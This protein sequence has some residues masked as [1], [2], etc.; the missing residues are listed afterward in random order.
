[1]TLAT[2]SFLDTLKAAAEEANVAEAEY[3]REAAQRIAAL[4]RQRAF[5]FRRLNLMRVVAD[6]VATAESEEI[7]VAN[8]LA[9]LRGKLGWST[10]TE[11][12]TEVLSR[13]APVA[14]AAFRSFVPS[15]DGPSLDVPDALA[16]FE[17]WYAGSHG[18]PFWAL[19]E[20]YIAETPLVDF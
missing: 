5:A 13:F 20:H 8:A 7:A 4:E 15:E 9:V 18:T 10:D 3:R 6:A 14:K 17:A 2:T 19:F 16:Q 11:A 12:T 1:M